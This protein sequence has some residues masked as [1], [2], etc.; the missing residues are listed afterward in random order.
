MKRT[1]IDTRSLGLDIGLNFSKWLTG[2]ENLHYGYW[3]GLDVCAANFGAAQVA[4]T[5]LLFER[6][7]EAPCRILDIGGSGG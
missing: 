7:P 4:Y 5:D 3:D 1:K 6:L 2:A